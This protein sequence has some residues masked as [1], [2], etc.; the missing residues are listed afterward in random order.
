M[1]ENRRRGLAPV[2][3]PTHLL[4]RDMMPSRTRARG[5]YD[6]DLTA[7]Q[8]P[9]TLS[10]YPDIG[11]SGGD[12]E[13]GVL[14][15]AKTGYH[16]T[17]PLRHD[18]AET[19]QQWLREWLWMT[20]QRK[21]LPKPAVSLTISRSTLIHILS[22]RP[23]RSYFGVVLVIQESGAELLG[24][25]ATLRG[26]AAFSAVQDAAP[27]GDFLAPSPATFRL[28]LLPCSCVRHAHIRESLLG[29]GLHGLCPPR[30]CHQIPSLT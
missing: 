23:A 19:S 21:S 4:G 2:V 13:R 17:G 14:Q 22:P 15:A 28:L 5:I 1:R 11:R 12:G 9:W 20:P 3:S 25:D 18:A 16:Q 27:F 26:V 30:W 8:A 7:S 24:S 10:R 6:G 29:P